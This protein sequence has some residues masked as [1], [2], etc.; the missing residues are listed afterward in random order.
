MILIL[1]GI[2]TVPLYLNHV[3]A[4]FLLGSILAGIIF[5]LK[6]ASVFVPKPI[7]NLAQGILGCL[8]AE[9]ITANVLNDLISYWQLALIIT[10]STIFISMILGAFLVRFSTLSAATAI[11][12][13]MPGGASVMVGI[14][15]DY[16]ADPRLVALIQY[17]RV[18]FVVTMLAIFSHFF[19]LE[20]NTN[21]ESQPQWL[22]APSFNLFYTLAIAMVGVFFTRLIKFPSGRVL[23]PMII[24]ACLQINGFIQIET[25][26]WL[27]M[28]CFSSIGLSVGLRFNLALIKIAIRTLPMI[29]LTIF[30][31]LIFCY[32]QAILLNIY[33]GIDYLTCFLATSPG[34]LETSV[35]L[36]LD[37][38]SDL[39]IILPLQILR[40]FSVLIF[41]PIIANYIAKKL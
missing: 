6:N 30:F 22:A 13:I 29:L 2:I 15:G 1:Y 8:I 31:M 20:I 35:I 24:G 23:L 12:G 26:P 16:G 9:A 11:W 33:L 27:L 7:F 36:A 10:V 21:V 28:L 18:I 41:G 37:T 38:H 32:M 5:A 40:L 4:A 14:C 25:P 17:C 34:G 3:P 19:I 39:A